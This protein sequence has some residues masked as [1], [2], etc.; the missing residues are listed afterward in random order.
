MDG[1]VDGWMVGRWMGAAWRAIPKHHPSIHP[2]ALSIRGAPLGHARAQCAQ[3]L[4]TGG[5]GRRRRLGRLRGSAQWHA[6]RAATHHPAAQLAGQGEAPRHPLATPFIPRAPLTSSPPLT[7]SER[8][9]QEPAAPCLQAA[10]LCVAGAALRQ[11]SV[12]RAT[13]RTEDLARRGA[14]NVISALRA[15]IALCVTILCVT[16]A[17]PRSAPHSAPGSASP[18]RRGSWRRCRGCSGP[19]TTR[20]SEATPRSTPRPTTSL[21]CVRR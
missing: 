9:A 20:G 1:W 3:L 11:P 14:A 17:A 16:H 15:C 21:T 19:P 6:R 10:T 8:H 13:A 7:P 4:N 12:L 18:S 2:S 5:T